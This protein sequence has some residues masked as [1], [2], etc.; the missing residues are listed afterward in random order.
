MSSVELIFF[1]LGGHGVDLLEWECHVQVL[2]AAAQL[3]VPEY[4]HPLGGDADHRRRHRDLR[5]QPAVAEEIGLL[6]GG[7]RGALPVGAGPP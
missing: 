1:L 7:L 4:Q 6:V 3:T 5:R 2:G